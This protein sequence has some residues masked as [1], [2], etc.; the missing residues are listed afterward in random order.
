[1]SRHRRQLGLL[2]ILT[3]LGWQRDPQLWNVP[4]LDGYGRRAQLSVRLGMG[5][6][7]LDHPDVGLLY[8]TPPQVGKLRGALRHALFDLELF[9]GADLPAPTPRS[10][11]M[12]HVEADPSR[13]VRVVFKPPPPRPTVAGIAARLAAS[14]SAV[15]RRPTITRPGQRSP[16]SPMQPHDP[17]SRGAGRT[18]GL[19]TVSAWQKASRDQATCARYQSATHGPFSK[20]I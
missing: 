11:R 15:D 20:L 6:V 13:R 19:A 18:G 16:V 17:H 5:W 14:A 4:C 3:R 12:P 2:A 8:L 10:E 1:M 7:T 9:G